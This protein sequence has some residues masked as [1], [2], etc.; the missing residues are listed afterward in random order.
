MLASKK[1]REDREALSDAKDSLEVLLD[2]PEAVK[3]ISQEILEVGGSHESATC[4]KVS[5]PARNEP[6]VTISASSRK[7]V[8]PSLLMAWSSMPVLTLVEPVSI[9]GSYLG[10]DKRLGSGASVTEKCKE[11]AGID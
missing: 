8:D 7:V 6:F 11:N 9:D 4:S 5:D 3:D 2:M 10:S 1:D